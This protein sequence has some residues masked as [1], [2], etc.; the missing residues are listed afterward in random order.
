M[1]GW[2]LRFLAFA[3]ADHFDFWYF[4]VKIPGVYHCKTPAF[5]LHFSLVYYGAQERTSMEKNSRF[6]VACD[7]IADLRTY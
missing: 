6:T 5:L 2:S 3:Y 1:T 4:F 7:T